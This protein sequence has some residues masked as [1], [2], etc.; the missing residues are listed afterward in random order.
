METELEHEEHRAAI[1]ERKGIVGVL[2]ALVRKLGY[3]SRVWM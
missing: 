2:E 1:S 3:L